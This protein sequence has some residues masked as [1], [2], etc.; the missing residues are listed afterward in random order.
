M[1]RSSKLA[2]RSSERHEI[3][4]STPVE[5]RMAE[6]LVQRLQ[7]ADQFPPFTLRQVALRSEGFISI[8]LAN[9]SAIPPVRK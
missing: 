8:V 9:V 2:W 1:R 3:R 5:R 6:Q 7:R 4:Y